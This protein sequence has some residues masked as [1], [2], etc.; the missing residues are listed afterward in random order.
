MKIRNRTLVLLVGMLFLNLVKAQETEK[1]N[2]LFIFTDDQTYESIHALN[3]SEIYTPNMDRLVDEGVTFTHAFNQGSWSVAVCVASRSMLITGQTVFRAGKNKSYLE[4]WAQI[5]GVEETEV[6]LWSEVLQKNGYE[7]YLTGKWH[8]TDYAAL[9]GF[10]IAESIG[11]GMYETYDTHGSK[12][13]GYNRGNIHDSEWRPTKK[14]FAGHWTPQVKDLIYNEKGE[15]VIGSPYIAKEHTTELYANNAINYLLTRGKEI[16][17]PFF[18]YV[19]FNAPHDPRQ[20]PQKYVDMYPTNSI[21]IPENYL[22]EH[23]FDQGDSKGRDEL[24]AP[25]PRSKEAVQLHRSEYYAIISHFDHEL[26]RILE[27][28]EASG[29]KENTYVILTSDHGLAVGQHGLMGKQNQYDHSVRMPLL[30][31]GPGLRKGKKVAEMVYLQSM[32]ATT[33]ELS[34]IKIPSTVEFKSIANL[35]TDTT[36]EAKGEEYI[37]GAYKGL[38]RMI[39][40][41][42]YKLIIYP[43]ADEYQLFD[44]NK[45]SLEKENL[46]GKKGYKKITKKLMQQIRLKQE[47]L[48]DYI[49][50]L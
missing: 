17:K 27:A 28:L 29:K 37:F 30:I 38:Q 24:L 10:D 45:D 3:N 18:M 36:E 14:E 41:K 39:R 15:A 4:K 21:K 22:L 6:P 7:T 8:N 5:E 47:E 46:Y 35:L 42:D 26:G 25:F 23:P 20:S 12:E 2:Y 48:K 1:P 32:F 11:Q 13:P 43:E 44:L 19:A 16:K 9:K 31:S 34:K 50:V 33:C 40:S 49:K